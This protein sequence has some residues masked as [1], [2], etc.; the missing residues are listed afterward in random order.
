M[1]IKKTVVFCLA[2]WICSHAFSQK[3]AD[4]IIAV[5]GD[6]YILRSE[7]EGDKATLFQNLQM[8]KDSL[9]LDCYALQQLIIRKL[10]SNQAEI[11]S[12]PLEDARVYS[13]IDNRIRNFEKKAGSQKELENYLGMSVAAYKEYIYPRMREQLLMTEMQNKITGST[14]ITPTEVKNFFDS[15]PTD[16]LPTV[17]MEVEVAQLIMIPPITDRAKAKARYKIESLRTKIMAGESFEGLA[18]IYSEDPGSAIQGGLLPEFGRGEMVPAFERMAFRSPI[19]SVTQIFESNFGFHI[20]KV[21][22]R[23]GEKVIAR[24]ILIKPQL[25]EKEL[26]KFGLSADSVYKNLITGK[27]DWCS[28]VKK[29]AHTEYGNR[30][31]CGFISDETTG[32]TKVL[33][34]AL[35]ADVKNIISKLKPGDF[36]KPEMIP[37][38]DGSYM[39]VMLYLKSQTPPHKLNFEKDYPRIFNEAESLKKQKMLEEWVEKARVKNN[40][41]INTNFLDCP[42][43]RSWNT[44]N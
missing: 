20:M 12:L 11:D 33:Y 15:I 25:D 14:A 10:L 28:A 40:V 9:K 5:I 43:L 22:S 6:K 1:N 3:Y 7:Y 13:E 23:S 34:D 31:N 38:G 27:M 21:I 41:T 44:S 18:K 37:T 30:G 42:E 36:S 17:P 39:F 8:A 2:C 35:S 19:D 32:Y 29:N 4:G 16:S 24:H 26:A